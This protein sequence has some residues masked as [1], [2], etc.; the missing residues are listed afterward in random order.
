M[1]EERHDEAAVGCAWCDFVEWI[2]HHVRYVMICKPSQI[3]LNKLR[4][5]SAQD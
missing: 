2:E 1:D 5:K 4:C 3:A